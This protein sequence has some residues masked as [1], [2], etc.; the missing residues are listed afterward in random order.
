M[1]LLPIIT[2]YYSLTTPFLSHCH[3]RRTSIRNRASSVLQKNAKLYGPRNVLDYHNPLSCWNSEGSPQGSAVENWLR[4][5]FGRSVQICELRIQFQAGFV[6]ETMAIWALL[7]NNNNNN[8]N[9][10]DEEKFVK[11]SEEEVEDNHDVQSFL[12]LSSATTRATTTTTA[13]KLVFDECTD[14]YG[15]ITIY[16]LQVMGYETDK[17]IL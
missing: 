3:L 16:Q 12:L 4:I 13:I 7:A 6:A 8:N 11:L 15:R 5:D 14:F 10:N 2:P 9:D 1:H 17:A